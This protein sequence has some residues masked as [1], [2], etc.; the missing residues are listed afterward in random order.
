MHRDIR[1]HVRTCQCCIVSKVLEP[2]GRAL[3][4]I[5]LTS[6][7]LEQVCI[8]FWSAEDSSNRSVDVLVVTDHFT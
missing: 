2:D 1:D 6:R 3:L 5:I 4:K 8:D 7:P